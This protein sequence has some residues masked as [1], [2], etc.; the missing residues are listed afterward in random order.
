MWIRF[1]YLKKKNYN[2]KMQVVEKDDVGMSLFTLIELD[3]K[4][5]VW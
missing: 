3:F 4:S 1:T 5:N 2:K